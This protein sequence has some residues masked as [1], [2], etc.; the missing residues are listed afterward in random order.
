MQ[1]ALNFVQT[2]IIYEMY[3]NLSLCMMK[4]E[5]NVK[6]S[7]ENISRL[8][9]HSLID[10]RDQFIKILHTQSAECTTRFNSILNVLLL[11]DMRR[12]TRKITHV[13]RLLIHIF[14]KTN[15]TKQTLS[16]H[17]KMHIHTGEIFHFGFGNETTH[18]SP[19]EVLCF[20]IAMQCPF[21]ISPHH[22]QCSL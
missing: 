15:R 21:S 22:I 18:V 10:F 11:Q 2:P 6:L 12:T 16:L 19:D 17:K 4:L 3:L 8:V 20:K 1:K 9:I 5:S 7:S 13:Q 14:K